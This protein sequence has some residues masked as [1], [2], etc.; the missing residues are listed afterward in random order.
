MRQSV[1]K[2]LAPTVLLAVAL[3][4]APAFSARVAGTV[5]SG[6]V[7]SVEGLQI[8]VNGT[9]YTVQQTGS[10]VNQLQQVEPG[11]VVDLVLNGPAGASTTVVVAIHVHPAS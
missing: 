3:H 6:T 11:E 7:S 5:V 4:A 9:T 10:A 2:K 1:W 8:V